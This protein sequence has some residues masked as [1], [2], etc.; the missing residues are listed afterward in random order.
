MVDSMT[1]SNAQS[2]ALLDVLSHY[3]VY[4]EIHDFRLPGTLDAYGPPFRHKPGQPSTTP[5]LQTLVTTFLTTLPGF[6]DVSQDF[7]RTQIETI[8]SDLEKAELSE[9]Y[10]KGN[11]GIRKTLATAIAALLEYVVRGVYAGFNRP[12]AVPKA[13]LDPASY[14]TTSAQDLQ[15]AFRDC[16]QQAVY[17]N[18]INEIFDKTAQTDKLSEH[19]AL[20]QASHEF[21]LV[22]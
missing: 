13:E 7:Y 9:S 15:R 22:K 16:M 6:R 10:D 1:L 17:G 8:I 12:D 5:S 3:E 18:I 2:K 20:V 19:S 21:G 14:D 11:L 4:Q